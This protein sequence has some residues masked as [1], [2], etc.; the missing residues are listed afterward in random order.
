MSDHPKLLLY[1]LGLS[2]EHAA[3]L[4]RLL[5]KAPADITFALIENAADVV[6]N[7]SG[8]VEGIRD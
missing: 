8:W 5:G 7:S 2:D 4:A 1:S 6:N 3:A